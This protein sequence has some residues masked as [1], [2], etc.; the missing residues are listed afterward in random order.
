MPGGA[1]PQ[2]LARSPR[3]ITLAA[4]PKT[5]ATAS[6]AQRLADPVELVVAIAGQVPFGQVEQD[7]RARR[8]AKVFRSERCGRERVGG[9]HALDLEPV[10]LAQQCPVQ[11]GAAG[12]REPIAVGPQELD[13][14]ELV[15]IDVL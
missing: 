5:S 11:E 14:G 15:G 8:T 12:R 7:H 9:R 3:T 4:A 6:L 13:T 1:G 10:A 2:A